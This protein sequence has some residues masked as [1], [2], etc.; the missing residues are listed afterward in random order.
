[1]RLAIVCEICVSCCLCAL[2]AAAQALP[3]LSKDQRALL[4]AVVLAVDG[5]AS[6]APS[7]EASW[8]LHVMRASDG[9]HY[10][11]FSV[12]PTGAMTLPAGPVLLYL[13]LATATPG[14]VTTTERSAIRDWLVGR[15]VDP[16]L[17]PGR[18]IAIGEMPAFG[19]GAIGVRGSTPSTGSM[20]LKLMALE[21]ERARQEQETRDKQRRTELDSQAMGLRDVLPF[22]DFDLASKSRAADGTRQISRAF[23]AGPG[24]YDLYVGWADTSST[25]PAATIRVL[26]RSVTLPPATASGLT[27]GSVIIA[28]NVQVRA[29]PYTPAEQAAHPY[30]IGPT[31]ITPARDAVFTREE[32]LAVT[33]QVINAMSSD[34]GKP[35]V[36]VAFRVVRVDGDREVPV[37]AL[38]PQTYADAS[39][40]P[41]FDLRLG[42][43]LFVAVAAPMATVPRGEYRLKILVTDRLAGVSRAADADFRIIGTPL[44]LLAEAPP[45]GHPFQREEALTDE[46]LSAVAQALTPANPSPALQRALAAASARKFIDLLVEEPVPAAEQGVRAALTGLAL[47][48]IGDASAVVQ[49]Q[50]GLTL[51]AP[52]APVQFLIAAARATQKR[53]PDAIVAW[54]LALDAG[55]PSA[56]VTPLLVEAYLRRGEGPRAE[57]LITAELAGRPAG[58]SWARPRAATH[59]AAGRDRDAMA[60]LDARLSQNPGDADASW[61]LLQALYGSMVRGTNKAAGDHDRFTTAAQ[62]Y[63]AAGGP[64]AALAAEWLKA[65]P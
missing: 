23:T 17:L 6:Q 27:L 60:V 9:S 30:A 25:K 37:A 52:A 58:G 2:P 14:A 1:M 38:N 31:E 22:E 47:Y 51:A 61:L 40:P 8:P 56:V 29:I 15:R 20:D 49:L 48:T 36:V 59:L 35:D 19:A 63:I 32:R 10:V 28:D 54:Q 26:K 50:R 21:R 5:A 45:L 53:D 13:R 18:G 11:A 33:F 57:A 16:R 7:A 34:T 44:S 3:E 64:N 65:V 46:A 55:L 41:D 4:Q 62:A 24:S 12:E 39:M 42:H 43:P